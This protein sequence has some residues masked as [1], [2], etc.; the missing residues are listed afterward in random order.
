MMRTKNGA[1]F[2]ILKRH[3]SCLINSVIR[4]GGRNLLLAGTVALQ[5]T[6]D[7][8]TA[9]PFRNDKEYRYRTPEDLQNRFDSTP[10]PPASP[11]ASRPSPDSD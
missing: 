10:H 9:T 11:Y 5:A 7:S 6:A 1:G 3:V 2:V 8:S 4:T